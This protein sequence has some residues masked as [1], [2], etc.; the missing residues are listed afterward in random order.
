MH[1]GL[2]VGIP[3]VAIFGPTFADRFGPKDLKKNRVI[4]SH[5]ACNPCWHP[6]TPIGCEERNCL[7]R[8]EVD[9]VLMVIDELHRESMNTED[10]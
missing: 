1:I 5:L 10:R 4:H 7:K 8:V 9:E 2:A 6:D 3:T